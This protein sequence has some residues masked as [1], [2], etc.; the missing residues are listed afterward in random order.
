MPKLQ[1]FTGN[2]A[3][4]KAFIRGFENRVANKLLTDTEKLDCLLQYVSGEAKELIED[5]DDLPDGSG[6]VEVRRLLDKRYGTTNKAASYEQRLMGWP[7]LAYDDAD[8]L[9]K[10]SVFIN[11]C[12]TAM[13][14]YEDLSHLDHERTIQRLVEK[15]SSKLKA[16]WCDQASDYWETHRCRLRFVDFARFV[17][18]AAAAANNPYYSKKALR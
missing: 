17:E 7:E 1:V 14:I 5:T 2:R 6:Y 18:R 8:G 13:G 16:R 15:L 10:F 9:Q 11:K 12:L 3:D 4:Y